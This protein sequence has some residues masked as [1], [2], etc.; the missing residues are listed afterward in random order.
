MS[1]FA[2]P[3]VAATFLVAG[4]VKGVTGMGLPTLAMD[5]LGALLSPLTA[6]SLLIVPSIITNLRQVLAGPRIGALA[7]RLGPMMEASMAS[8]QV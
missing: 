7:R 1:D 3:H 4:I 2:I 8:H 5:L 6:A